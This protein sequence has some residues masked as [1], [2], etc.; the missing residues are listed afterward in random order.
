M[1]NKKGFT[2]IE[3]L[4]VIAIIGILSSIVIASLN[5]ARTKTAV[6]SA[7]A[8][9]NQIATQ[10]EV[11]Y[12]N[13][14][15]RYYTSPTGSGYNLVAD[16]LDPNIS[17]MVF[18]DS[19]IKSMLQQLKTNINYTPGTDFLCKVSGD[20][21]SWFIYVNLRDGTN[22]CIDSTGTK[23]TGTYTY[24]ITYSPGVCQ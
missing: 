19:T 8:Q 22:Y 16:C 4:V 5:A 21:Q 23:K 20:V 13:N 7:K 12:Q 14:N 6:A 15:N 11:F 2:L 3:L 10:T 17:S 24:S 18:G 1:K 9:L